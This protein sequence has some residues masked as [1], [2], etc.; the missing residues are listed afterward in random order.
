MSLLPHAP[1]VIALFSPVTRVE[2]VLP[3][4]GI[5]TAAVSP[6]DKDSDGVSRRPP[7]WSPPNQ[8]ASDPEA[9][10]A[11]ILSLI[12]SRVEAGELSEDEAAG[13]AGLLFDSPDDQEMALDNADED[14]LAGPGEDG[15]DR[16]STRDPIADFLRRVALAQGGLRYGEDGRNGAAGASS[17]L[18]FEA[19]V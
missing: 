2:S 17:P 7:E 14:H 11:R 9:I 16:E 1:A 12:G 6:L 18:L 10:G 13:L 5:Y 8:D 4:G 15:P 3:R 19:R